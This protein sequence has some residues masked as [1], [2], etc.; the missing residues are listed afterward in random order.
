MSD[1]ATTLSL[2]P[3]IRAFRPKA[4]GSIVALELPA[5]AVANVIDEIIEELVAERDQKVRS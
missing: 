2:V 3:H 5:P 4:P 1:P